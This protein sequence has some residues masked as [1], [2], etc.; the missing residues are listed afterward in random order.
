M[1]NE[2]GLTEAQIEEIAR[3]IE[4][5]SDEIH[6]TAAK[7]AMALAAYAVIRPMCLR[8]AI[9]ATMIAW[10]DMIDPTEIEEAF[11]DGILAA[12]DA[13]LS[14]IPKEPTNAK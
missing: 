13:I 8:E 10:V 5:K 4:A 6:C 11:N 3:A 2:H 12:R 1:G 9:S 7:R 14:L